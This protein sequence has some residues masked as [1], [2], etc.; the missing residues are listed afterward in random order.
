MGFRGV[1]IGLLAVLAVTGVALEPAAARAGSL[2]ST[3][4][5][6]TPTFTSPVAATGGVVA[7]AAPSGR[8]HRFE[9]L[10]RRAG[11]THA[12]ASTS[13]V[14]WID[15]V[16]LGTDAH[17]RAIVVYSRCPHSPFASATA[18]NAATDGCL[19]WWARLSGGGPQRI[20]AAPVDTTVGSATAGRVVFAVQPNTG[21]QRQ[22]ARLETATITGHAAHALVVPTPR[23]ATIGDVSVAGSDVVFIEEPL[24]ADPHM[25]P[26]QVWLDAPGAAPALLAQQISDGVQIDNAARFFDG[27]TL[28]GSDVYAFLYANSGVFPAAA[29]EL[30]QIP[31]AG[32][33][34]P[35][36]TAPWMPSGRLRSFGV[37][38]AAFD[39]S[40]NQLVLDLFSQT[41]DLSTPS[42]A[43]S[44][45]ASSTKA[46]PIVTTGPVTFP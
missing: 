43:C 46:C 38:A 10:I 6:A 21:H 3:S 30:E 2:G 1:G 27:V 14:G 29:S 33:A 45:H 28:K 42:G 11:A 18:G 36:A 23:G 17:G 40:D 16:K 7:W 39:P 35:T 13:A 31:L 20:A 4:V 34:T 8:G 24:V 22:P 41:V 26:S 9:I 44:S 12:L 19:L 37:Q 32:G 5:L 25:S 15:G